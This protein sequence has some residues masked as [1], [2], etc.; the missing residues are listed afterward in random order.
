VSYTTPHVRS[1]DAGW[2]VAPLRTREVPAAVLA[3][4][5]VPA[6]VPGVVHTDLLSA[7]L[8]G[9]PYR[10]GNERLEEWIGRTPWRYRT[11]FDAEVVADRT[12]LVFAGLDTVA[13]VTLNGEVVLEAR[14]QH[15]SYRV[16]VRD[17]LRPVGNELTVDFAAPVPYADAE[18]LRLGYRPHVN[19]HPFNAMRKMACSFGWDWGIDTATSGIWQPV[20]LEAWSVARLAAVRP[21]ATLDGD[22]GHV[23]IH[24][25]VERVSDEP[26]TLTATVA[27][28]SAEVAL[29]PGEADAVLHLAVENARMWWPVGYGDQPL[30][31]LA[32]TLSASGATLDHA[33]RRIGF[34]DVRIDTTPDAAGVP[35]TLVVN[36]RAVWV[37][38]VNWIPDDAFPHRVD[39]DRYAR[40]LDQAVGAHVNLVRVWG[41]GRYE[42]DDFYD[43]AD[44]R[45]L[46]VWQDFA[47]ACAAYA[48]E[49]PLRSEIEAEARQNVARL[50]GHPALV[51]LNGNNENLWGYE[52]WGW[53]ARLEGRTWG[54][55]YY[56]DLF[57]RIVAE[58]APHVAYTPGSPF[59]PVPGDNPN[60]EPNGTMHLWDEWNREDYT[61]YRTWRPRFVAEFG[62]QG[63][64]AW[65][66]LTSALDDDPLTPES[67]G[68]Q[69]HQKAADGNV[70]LT[71]GLLPH[72]PL[73]N[74]MP[75]WHWAMQLNQANA[76]RT[77][78]EHFRS[79]APHCSGA[80]VWQLNDS[81]PVVSWAAVDGD[82][83]EKPMWYALRAAFAPRLL[84]VQPD[85]EHLVMV[86]VNDTDE[87]WL[88]QARVVRHGF[89][90]SVLAEVTLDVAVAPRSPARLVLPD[91]VATPTRPRSELVRAELD[92][93][94]GDWFFA[95][96]RDCELDPAKLDVDVVAV[97]RGAAVTVTARSLV[98]DL[99]IL[100]D[101]V[102]PAARA[103][104][105]LLTLL[106]GE[107]ATIRVASASGDVAA[108]GRA[109]ALRTANELLA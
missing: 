7:G 33:A 99:T 105:A 52:D 14:N 28:V 25:A 55:G 32:V 16:P 57:P 73:P 100:A 30:Y 19:H 95:E 61:H 77:A 68:M 59:S 23:A 1:L 3:A 75:E 45:G 108:F 37:K 21:V 9:D 36:G 87:P 69:V 38:G 104:D 66:T 78:I 17:L 64:P 101:V 31:D 49:E 81:W 47:L 40:R 83:R 10:G 70:K 72:L 51:V 50:A 46:L 39:R 54:A 5:E 86:A 41:G 15:R 53:K 82:G 107:E 76:V 90:G 89:D 79:I 35:F 44:E 62:W 42:S 11:V 24:V 20:T 18:S 26:V 92:G 8:I 2:A 29:G 84:S 94:R 67:P 60:S 80:I 34:R 4:G 63:P 22:T 102:D 12:D 43:L 13:T 6:T 65:A 109:P 48:E 97:P 88:G 106:P 74:S 103:D 56:H 96:Y 98:R 93:V 91:E 85:G 58:L 27:G 71:Y